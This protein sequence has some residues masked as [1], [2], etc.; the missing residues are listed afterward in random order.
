MTDISTKAPRRQGRPTGRKASLGAS[1]LVRACMDL[2]RTVTPARLTFVVLARHA[3][4]T[5]AMINYYFSDRAELMT[6][7][8]RGIADEFVTGP[9][10]PL[11]ADPV[12]RLRAVIDNLVHIHQKYPYIHDLLMT[13]VLNS[14]SPQGRALFTELANAAAR[15]FRD[16][17]A[18][19]AKDGVF[20]PMNPAHL[21]A[22]V[23]GACAFFRTGEMLM[24]HVAPTTPDPDAFAA[25]LTRLILEGL[26]PRT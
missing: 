15:Q 10:T 9:D 20:V 19:G 6:A 12:A 25:D 18:D 11:P 5:P 7:V 21:T 26:R 13:E 2:L 3:G 24:A 22:T 23:V 17:I 14:D 16:L 1:E 4:V 8:A